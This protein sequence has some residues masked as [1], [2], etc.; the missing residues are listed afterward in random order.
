MSIE[1]TVPVEDR[2]GVV[3]TGLAI[4]CIKDQVL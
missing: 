1:L 3:V 2:N 4:G